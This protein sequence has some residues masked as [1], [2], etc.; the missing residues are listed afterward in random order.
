VEVIPNGHD[1]EPAAAQ[2]PDEFILTYMGS[3][4]PTTQDLSAVWPAIRRL[5]E[6]GEAFVDRIRFIGDLHPALRDQLDRH[7]L[8]S[9]VDVTGF[10]GHD[11]AMESLRRSS[12]LLLAG[13]KDAGGILRGQVAGKIPEYLATGLPIVYTGDPNCDAADLLRGHAGCH[14]VATGDVERMVAALAATSEG[15]SDR[16]VS[17]LSRGALTGRLAA[18]FET[19]AG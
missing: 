16:D 14:I 18:I 11:S 5:E 13:P 9:R 2:P 8:M 7:G 4:Y 6:S 3:F 1:L 15:Q 12:A 10:V 19:V 17:A